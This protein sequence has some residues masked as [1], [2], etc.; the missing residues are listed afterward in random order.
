MRGK[1]VVVF[2]A[3]M[4]TLQFSQRFVANA[5][6]VKLE[7]IM[8]KEAKNGANGTALANAIGEMRKL[9][10]YVYDHPGITLHD[11]RREIQRLKDVELVIVD[12][13]Q[14]LESTDRSENR[15]LEVAK[16]SGGLK[17]LAKEF[18]IPILALSQLNRGK[19][20]TDEPGL[21]ALRDSGSLEQDADSVMLAWK[22]EVPEGD[23]LTKI[24]LKVAKNRMGKSGTVVMYFDGAHMSFKETAEEYVP[25]RS[26]YG[27][28]FQMVS[29]DDPDF[30]FS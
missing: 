1:K 21:P 25:K 2:S 27:S 30:P 29:G 16:L 7:E 17:K 5:S 11:I 14:L 18:K 12:Y 15:N 10:L 9:P 4:S 22:L 24:G 19:D 26:G 8:S 6:N 28:Q 13:I 23:E 20:E 3:E